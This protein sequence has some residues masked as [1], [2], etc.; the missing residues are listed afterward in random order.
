MYCHP[1]NSAKRKVGSR[2]TYSSWLM[3]RLP[4]TKAE[5]KVKPVLVTETKS[6][7]WT[8]VLSFGC[9]LFF[10]SRCERIGEPRP[11]TDTSHKDMVLRDTDVV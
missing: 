10:T 5:A 2:S 9:S 7:S 4:R 11:A 6:E 1:K 8:H 3:R